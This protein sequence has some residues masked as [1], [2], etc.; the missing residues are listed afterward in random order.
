MKKALILVLF[1]VMALFLSA[2]GRGVLVGQSPPAEASPDTPIVEPSVASEKLE[3]AL[4]FSDW[5]A[6]H[7]IPEFREID[8]DNAN[9]AERVVKEFLK[10]PEQPHLYR[11][12]P[13]DA[14][15][16][17]V[18]V[19]GDTVYVNFQSGINIPGS[20][21]EGA[22]IRSLFLTLTDLPDIEKVQVLV[23]G[24]SDVS[25]GGHYLLSEPGERPQIVTYPIFLDEERAR[26]LQ[27]RADQGLETW[28]F[29][30]VQVAAREGRMLGFNEDSV[31]ELIETSSGANPRA[32]VKAVHEEQEYIIELVQPA[33][34][35]DTGV[36]M[37]IN[38]NAS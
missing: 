20:A 10:G 35:G 38:I 33:S 19:K 1:V 3:V 22:A 18:E 15:V 7:V 30:A 24:R 6:Q 32:Y 28:R 4:Y 31:F 5:Q 23:E 11:T 14:R 34:K 37:I 29:D 12:F 25:F 27:E 16:L 17:S 26:W 8:N 2:C 36:W 13:E 9:L 21:G